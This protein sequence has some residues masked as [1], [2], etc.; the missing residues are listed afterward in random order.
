MRH[1]YIFLVE[2]YLWEVRS[3]QRVVLAQTSSNSLELQKVQLV[4]LVGMML[5]IFARKDQLRYIRDVAT[6]TVGT[7]VMGKMVSYFGVELDYDFMSV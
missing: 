3:V 7:G 6:E 2:N 4:R 1:D 5:L